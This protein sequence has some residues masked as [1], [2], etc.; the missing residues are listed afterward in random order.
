MPCRMAERGSR[1]DGI[2]PM[3]ARL[4]PDPPEPA[5]IAARRG[6]P[7]H[8]PTDRSFGARPTKKTALARGLEVLGEPTRRG[9]NGAK[10]WQ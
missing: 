7:G 4:A 2:A 6:T 3:V 9:A 5:G 8:F 10:L 1:S